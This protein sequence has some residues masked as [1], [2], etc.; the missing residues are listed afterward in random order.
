[1]EVDLDCFTIAI[2]RLNKS[3]ANTSNFKE[4]KHFWSTNLGIFVARIILSKFWLHGKALQMTKTHGWMHIYYIKMF[5]KWW[6]IIWMRSSKKAQSVRKNP[7]KTLIA[8]EWLLWG[9][10]VCCTLF[11]CLSLPPQSIR[12]I[13]L[14]EFL[15]ISRHSGLRLLF[16]YR[17]QIWKLGLEE[18]RRV[19][20]IRVK[21]CRP[22]DALFCNMLLEDFRLELVPVFFCMFQF[23]LPIIL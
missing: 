22:D 7:N 21:P 9:T 13:F 20:G 3:Y 1:M 16:K 23:V 10:D 19:H 12:K 14:T 11:L 18:F 2:M 6:V 15:N 5:H 8:A 4:V 17:V